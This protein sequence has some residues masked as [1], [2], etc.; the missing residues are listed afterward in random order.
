MMRHT[1]NWCQTPPS[2]TVR[3][4]PTTARTLQL[5]RSLW[6]KRPN[7]QE[8]QG[9]PGKTHNSRGQEEALKGKLSWAPTL[10]IQRQEMAAFFKLFGKFK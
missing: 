7:Q 4:K 5:K 2:V 8:G 10:V 3:I 1:Q 9:P 6:L